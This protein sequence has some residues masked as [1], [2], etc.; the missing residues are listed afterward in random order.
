MYIAAL[1]LA[2]G[3]YSHGIAFS[4]SAP[5]GNILRCEADDAGF[6]RIGGRFS[7]PDHR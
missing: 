6:E 2:S 7:D 1:F 5:L 3:L 4:T